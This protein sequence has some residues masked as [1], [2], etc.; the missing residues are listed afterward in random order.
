MVPLFGE[1]AAEEDEDVRAA[2]AGEPLLLLALLGAH[3]A[4]FDAMQARVRPRR[5]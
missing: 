1:D 5:C 2:L 3:D 4:D